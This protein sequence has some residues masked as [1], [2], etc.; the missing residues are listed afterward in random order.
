M[1]GPRL[2]EQQEPIRARHLNRYWTTSKTRWERWTRLLKRFGGGGAASLAARSS[3]DRSWQR[4]RAA[5]QQILVSDVPVRVWTALLAAADHERGVCEAEPIGRSVLVAHAEVRCRALRLLLHTPGVQAGDAVRL[6]RLR[7]QADRWSDVFV[8]YLAAQHDVARFA[9]NP[10]RASEFANDF[11]E[12]VQWQPGGSG[13]WLLGRAWRRG[14]AATTFAGP[15]S[16]DGGDDV[17]AAMLECFDPLEL[18]SAGLSGS[19]WLMRFQ[20]TASQ[21]HDMVE[22]VCRQEFG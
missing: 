18:L 12:R 13:W 7:R 3:A 16:D 11:R 20:A 5:I 9:A 22:Q 6:N 19:L 2:I 4:A 10:S 1:H 15:R 8:G 21:T 17:S 14:L